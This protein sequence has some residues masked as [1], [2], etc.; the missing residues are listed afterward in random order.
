[1]G[2]PRVEIGA[3]S[4]LSP[5]WDRTTLHLKVAGRTVRPEPKQGVSEPNDKADTRGTGRA[6]FSLSLSPTCYRTDA[7]SRRIGTTSAPLL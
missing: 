1:M 4:Q 6:A 2:A 3:W 7:G 5:G